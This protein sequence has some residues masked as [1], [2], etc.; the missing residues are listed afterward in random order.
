MNQH[1]VNPYELDLAN[2]YQREIRET[3][4]ADTMTASY[5]TLSLPNIYTRWRKTISK[6]QKGRLVGRNASRQAHEGKYACITPEE[7]A[8]LHSI[9]INAVPTFN[10]LTKETINQ[11]LNSPE[12]FVFLTN[13]PICEKCQAVPIG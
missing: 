12:G 8:T 9:R 10:K 4:T 6:L 1:T 11:L 3:I 7:C 2:R 13:Q 5:R